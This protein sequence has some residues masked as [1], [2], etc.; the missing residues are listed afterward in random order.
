MKS[1]KF[2]TGDVVYTRIRAHISYPFTVVDV[3]NGIATCASYYY[4]RGKEPGVF[5][6][7]VNELWLEEDIKKEV[8]HTSS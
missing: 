8:S 3:L 2:K 7:P 5:E 4:G 1:K 6:I